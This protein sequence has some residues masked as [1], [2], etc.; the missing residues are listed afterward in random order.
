MSFYTGNYNLEQGNF[1][2]LTGI[3]ETPDQPL[4]KTLDG[5]T[6]ID[7]TTIPGT[8]WTYVADMDQKVSRTA[9]VDFHLV[10]CD[11]LEAGSISIG[12]NIVTENVLPQFDNEYTVGN[13]AFQY[14]EAYI[15]SIFGQIK[16]VA[17]PFITSLGNLT[18]LNL[19]GDTLPI[20][21]IAYD[22][23]S[24]IKRIKNIYSQSYYGQVATAAQ[25]GITSLGPLLYLEM[26]GGIDLN[27]NN[28]QEINE[29]RA[30]T[31]WG[32]LQT[33]A[34]PNVTSLGTLTALTMGGAINLQT[35]NINNINECKA[36]SLYGA[37]QTASQPNVTTLNGLQTI[38]SVFIPTSV[39]TYVASLNQPLN[40]V[41][42]P[43]FF[44]LTT[45]NS[46]IIGTHVLDAT[47][48]AFLKLINQNL[49]TS[50]TPTFS[51][52]SA[53]T[54]NFT[55]VNATNYSVTGD[56]DVEGTLTPKQIVQQKTIEAPLP[57]YTYGHLVNPT[58]EASNTGI[59]DIRN[60]S[61]QGDFKFSDS[62]T[63][64]DISGH[65]INN[66]VHGT[67]TITRLYGLK[68][69]QGETDGAMTVGT[70]YGAY[71]DTPI[72][73]TT[74][75]ALFANGYS[76]CTSGLTAGSATRYASS[77]YP[78]YAASGGVYADTFLAFSQRCII[79]MG[80]STTQYAT[81]TWLNLQ[82]DQNV[83]TT[84]RINPLAWW[85]SSLPPFITI[86][87]WGTY[88]V[89]AQVRLSDASSSTFGIRIVKSGFAVESDQFFP[90]D[91]YGRRC[92]Q[93]TVYDLGGPGSQYAIQIIQDGGATTTVTT[94]NFSVERVGL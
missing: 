50:G 72:N 77:D 34:Q 6:S 46:L 16:T 93:I 86:S 37:L 92:A 54:G 88:K 18:S 27:N 39:W 68:V 13:D 20:T 65:Y 17:Q 45:S 80:S 70:A 48:A 42:S 61:S 52:V 30:N 76:N 49:S 84:N 2:Y 51:T 89:S 67:G 11:I 29:C 14:K 62:R 12:G 41:N 55:T 90:P 69:T 78:V 24:A 79:S 58:Y 4:I 71:I 31:V 19:A 9:N 40:S 38:Q 43:T 56:L 28:I 5:L 26:V 59:A 83:R 7:H 21:D 94:A 10:H 82:F 3:L 60:I 23:G 87:A 91:T 22:V 36:V 81:N 63:V 75:Y 57:A 44:N 32:T 8:S 25:P 74:K 64:P 33:A 1:D 66:Y 73:G 53:T 85:S 47:I 35:N 15:Y